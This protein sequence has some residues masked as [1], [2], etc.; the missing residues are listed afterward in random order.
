MRGIVVFA[1]MFVGLAVTDAYFSSRLLASA[2]TE[3]MNHS[4]MRFDSIH[5]ITSDIADALAVA[6]AAT[7]VD[8]VEQALNSRYMQWGA[9]GVMLM[10]F[11]WLITRHIP[12]QE[13]RR[14]AE[15]KAE[16][17]AYTTERTAERNAFLAA[18]EKRDGMYL[19]TLS[20]IRRSVETH[21]E[22]NQK[23][24]E[25]LSNSVHELTMEIR[26]SRR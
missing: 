7:E 13:K 8:M 10:L 1:L 14:E 4:R 18:I 3:A 22:N 23:A 20:D 6:P 17:E 25:H 5:S 24:K 9:V 12:N 11:V 2:K 21:A 16:R 19:G 26:E 15:R